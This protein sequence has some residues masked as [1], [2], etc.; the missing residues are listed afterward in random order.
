MTKATFIRTTFNLG[1]LTGSEFQSS[2]SWWEHGSIQAGIVLEEL[3]VLCFAPKANRRLAS[4]QVR[5]GS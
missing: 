4:R 2:S 5:Q 3:R 1:W